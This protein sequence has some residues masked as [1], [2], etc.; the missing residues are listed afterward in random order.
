MTQR[1]KHADPR[2]QRYLSSKNAIGWQF[3]EQMQ[4]LG[5]VMLDGQ[6]PFGVSLQAEHSAGHQVDLDNILKA[7]LD[8]GNKILYPD[9]RWCDEIR[10][11]VR[12]NW[13]RDIAVFE[14]WT[15]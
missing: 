12:V 8:A 5:Y 15:L 7:V 6:T 11:T 4:A 10:K 13:G 1:S 2:A 3:K 14:V 9:D